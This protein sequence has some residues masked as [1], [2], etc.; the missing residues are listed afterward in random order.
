MPIY[1]SIRATDADQNIAV[2]S[3]TVTL[4]LPAHF[5]TNGV[6]NGRAQIQVRTA[7][8]LYTKNGTAPTAATESTGTKLK[9]GDFLIL[10]T[11]EEMNLLNMIRATGVDGAVFVEYSK[12]VTG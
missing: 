5:S 10:E 12:Y 7:A 11:L 1:S 2:S 4:T 8:I 6:N 9:V 3:S